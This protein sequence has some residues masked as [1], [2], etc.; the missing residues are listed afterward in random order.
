M[1]VS[2]ST[3]PIAGHPAAVS[4]RRVSRGA[5]RSGVARDGQGSLPLPVPP[6]P[7]SQA[8]RDLLADA[9]RGLGRAIRAD[10]PTDRYAAAHLAA[11]R[12]AAAVLATKARP[13]RSR[14]ASAWDLLAKVAPEFS[15]W[16]AFFAAGSAK[17]QA[18]EAGIAR[19]ISPREADD[20]VRQC[21]VFLDLVEAAL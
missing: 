6:R 8:A 7:V 17:R 18:A 5:G 13:G 16:S 3:R 9:G 14:Q 12:G 20:M 11:L 21:A 15:E 1:S 10:Q 2:I 4:G 19:F